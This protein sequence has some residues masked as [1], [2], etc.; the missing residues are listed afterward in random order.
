MSRRA[1]APGRLFLIG[2]GVGQVPCLQIS[3]RLDLFRPRLRFHFQP[4]PVPCSGLHDLR[5]CRVD[6]LQDA[7]GL[8]L[9]TLFLV[10]GQSVFVPGE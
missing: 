4:Q 8:A 2:F 10:F 7:G 5:S 1:W 3:F 9:Y 6:S